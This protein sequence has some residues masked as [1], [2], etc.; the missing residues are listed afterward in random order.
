MYAGVGSSCSGYSYS[1]PGKLGQACF[2]GFLYGNRIGL[3]LKT[4]I[5]AAVIFNNHFYSHNGSSP[6]V[7]LMQLAAA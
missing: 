5:I 3:Y 1:F 7:W 2:Q 4:M 6:W